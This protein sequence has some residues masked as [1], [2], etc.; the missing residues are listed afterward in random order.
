MEGV[1]PAGILLLLALFQLKHALIDGPLQ[2]LWMIDQKGQYGRPGGI[3]HAGLHGAGSFL[4]LLFFGLAPAPA[5]LLAAFDMII[6]YH[7]DF[8]KESLVRRNG[9][10]TQ[11]PA[12]WW[13]MMADQMIHQFTYLAMA[14]AV[15]MS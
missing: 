2:T 5:A 9:W 15:I 14:F 11:T 8:A 12:F 6:H 13:V 10:S 1:S 7:A 4:A 3:I